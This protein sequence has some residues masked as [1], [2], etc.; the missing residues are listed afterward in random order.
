M[1]KKWRNSFQLF[2]AICCVL[3]IQASLFA[4]YSQLSHVEH[5]HEDV[6]SPENEQDACHRAIYHGEEHS[7]HEAHIIQKENHCSLCLISMHVYTNT[8][9]LSESNLEATFSVV[10]GNI[11]LELYPSSFFSHKNKAPP[12]PLAV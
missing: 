2:A 1:D 10:D 9:Y 4:S 12:V 6:H 8:I 5:A 7:E 11:E 3:I